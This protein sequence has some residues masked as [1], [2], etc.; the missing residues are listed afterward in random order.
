MK[1]LKFDIFLININNLNNH[2]ID[3]QNDMFALQSEV[4]L[5][6]ETWMNPS[7]PI[8]WPGKVLHHASVGNGRG[9]C[10][11]TPEGTQDSFINDLAMPNYQILSLL[12]KDYQIILMYLSKECNFHEVLNSLNN[13]LIP[14][15]KSLVLGD[16]NFDPNAK[17]PNPLSTFLKELD[18]VQIVDFPTH[19]DGGLIDHI[20]TKN[21]TNNVEIRTNFPY[22]SDHMAFNVTLN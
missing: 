14:A 8:N 13:T 20:Y 11:F 18:F 15:K 16:L 9:V 17:K 5:L 7:Q 19:R 3:V 21:A 6:T 1:A 2:L 12:I 22:Y 10:A 4:I